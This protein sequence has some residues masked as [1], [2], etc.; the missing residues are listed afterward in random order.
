MLLIAGLGNPGKEFE[1]TRHNIG[2]MVVDKLIERLKPND[3][4][5]SSFKG[6]L[7]KKESILLLKPTTYMNLSGESIQLVSH[8][9]KIKN[10]IVVHDEIDLPFGTVRYKIGGGHGGHNG[11]KSVD[12]KIGNGYMRARIGVSKPPIKSMVPDYVL[13]PFSSEESSHI[14]KLIDDVAHTIFELIKGEDFV[15]LVS[16][17]SGKRI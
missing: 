14:P 1:Q 15:Q 17:R 12:Q 4:T 10:V 7:F 8:F 9:Y 13:S 5:K 16:K 6:E 3:V 11:L 2:F